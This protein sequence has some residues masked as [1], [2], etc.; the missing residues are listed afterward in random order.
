MP[1]YEIV[2]T[3]LEHSAPLCVGLCQPRVVPL[4]P[5]LVKLSAASSYF[6]HFLQE[7]WAN[8]I[9]DNEKNKTVAD[10]ESFRYTIKNHCKVTVK[11]KR[12]SYKYSVGVFKKP[13]VNYKTNIN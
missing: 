12:N 4:T 11:T 13:D 8:W 9:N 6:S 10:V 5:R 3:V 2:Y 7:T 1:R